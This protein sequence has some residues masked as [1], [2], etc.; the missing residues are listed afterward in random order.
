MTTITQ[1]GYDFIYRT[2]RP[3]HLP[4]VETWGIERVAAFIF[5]VEFHRRR[6]ESVK[7]GYTYTSAYG[8]IQYELEGF[9]TPTF[10]DIDKL[11]KILLPYIDNDLCSIFY[12][13]FEKGL[14]LGEA[15]LKEKVRDLEEVQVIRGEE[16]VPDSYYSRPTRQE[17]EAKHNEEQ[18]ELLKEVPESTP[19]EVIKVQFQAYGIIPCTIIR[20]TASFY[21]VEGLVNGKKI[22]QNTRIKKG[23]SRIVNE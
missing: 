8:S 15:M 7:Q 23:T 12:T 6:S 18:V 14:D 17:Y 9:D 1:D 5:L 3:G 19:G 4:V 13:T 22:I 2:K 11:T 10:Q 20:E 21:Y 16:V